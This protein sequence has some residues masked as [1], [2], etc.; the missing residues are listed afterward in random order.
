MRNFL[1]KFTAYKFIY[2]MTNL[3]CCAE[4][5]WNIKKLIAAVL[6]TFY[7]PVIKID[8]NHQSMEPSTDVNIFK[9]LWSPLLIL[10]FPSLIFN[11]IFFHLSEDYDKRENVNYI[12][13]N[14]RV[15]QEHWKKRR[16]QP[17]CHHQIKRSRRERVDQ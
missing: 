10:F 14:K 5:N 2:G 6:P 9:F 3:W 13:C 7:Q 15:K 17:P 4:K 11:W 8:R 1:I 12:S 16:H